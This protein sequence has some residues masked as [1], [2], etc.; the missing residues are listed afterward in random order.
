MTESTLWGAVVR[1]DTQADGTFV[2]AV[3]ST[4][5]YCRPS[6]PS[7]R[8]RASVV[9]FYPGAA[10]A[11]QA[12]FRPCRRCHPRGPAP[13]DPRVEKVRRVCAYLAHHAD[14]AATLAV[15]GRRVGS[16]PH[17]LQR[18]FKQLLG[19]S[20]RQYAEACRMGRFKAGLR[21]G[22]GVTGAI[23]EAGYGS[24]SRV[25]EHAAERIGMTPATYARG[26]PGLVVR[27]V[28]TGC[29]LGHMLVAATPRGICAVKLGGNAEE[30]TNQLRAEYPAATISTADAELR[31]WVEGVLATL[32]GREPAGELPL[33]VRGTA[34][35]WRVWQELRAIPRGTTRSY[36]EVARH[37]GRPKAVR[38]VARACAT[39]PVCLLIPCHRVVPQHGGLGG[40]RWGADRKRV[41]LN[42]ERTRGSCGAGAPG[43]V[44][45]KPL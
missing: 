30:L 2:Y 6:C 26:G 21:N 29:A 5:I 44:V 39:N 9:A 3:R 1:R 27:Y 16:S 28:V 25:Y 8:P 35:Q 24:S 37:I 4:G 33:D 7:R 13:P 34:F 31:G 10:A 19:I 20:P 17:H 45:T 14:G 43:E 41:L 15:L 23:Y 32:A 12:G 22:T 11:E 18:T 38:A 42:N 40:Y 36:S